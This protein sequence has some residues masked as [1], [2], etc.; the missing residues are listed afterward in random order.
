M[1]AF[2]KAQLDQ[3]L[4]WLDRRG[5]SKSALEDIRCE[6]LD[7]ESYLDTEMESGQYLPVKPFLKKSGLTAQDWQSS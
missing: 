1:H 5:L 3:Y 7:H 4:D 6:I 2:F